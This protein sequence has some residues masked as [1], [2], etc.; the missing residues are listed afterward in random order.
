MTRIG[1]VAGIGPVSSSKPNCCGR[2]SRIVGPRAETGSMRAGCTNGEG[3][4]SRAGDLES[5]GL[6]DVRAGSMDGIEGRSADSRRQRD[7]RSS[8]TAHGGRP[9]APYQLGVLHRARVAKPITRRPPA[10][11]L[12]AVAKNKAGASIT[13]VGASAV[14]VGGRRVDHHRTVGGERLRQCSRSSM[15]SLHPDAERAPFLGDSANLVCGTSNS[16]RA[17]GLRATLD[18]STT[19]RASGCRRRCCDQGHGIDL[20]AHRSRYRRCDTRRRH[21]R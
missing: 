11:A 4:S 14:D 5:T 3:A 9:P 7:T 19:A 21:R 8:R 10:R 2:A 6:M 20:P 17:A 16:S 13:A 18:G 1:R 12:G 15:A